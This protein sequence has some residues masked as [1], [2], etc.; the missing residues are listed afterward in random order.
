MIA[1]KDLIMTELDIRTDVS[2]ISTYL[3]GQIGPSEEW[4]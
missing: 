4:V 1:I 2:Y 3:C